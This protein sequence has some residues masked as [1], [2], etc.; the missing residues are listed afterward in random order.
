[1]ALD[2]F[3]VTGNQAMIVDYTL[4]LSFDLIIYGRK[5]SDSTPSLVDGVKMLGLSC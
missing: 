3:T 2:S 4:I 1:M 5:Q